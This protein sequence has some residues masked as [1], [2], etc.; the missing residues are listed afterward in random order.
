MALN[1][2][3]VLTQYS[4]ENLTKYMDTNNNGFISI[5]HFNAEINSA[6]ALDST[7]RSGGTTRKWN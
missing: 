2:L 7:Q 5:S 6:S 1:S 3:Q 4:I